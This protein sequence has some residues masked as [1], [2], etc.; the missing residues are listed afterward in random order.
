MILTGMVTIIG[1]Q[2]LMAQRGMRRGAPHFAHRGARIMVVKRSPFLPAKVVV[3]HPVWCPGMAIYRRWVFFPRYNFY[4][5]NWRNCYFFWQGGV[6]VTSPTPPP[7]V[8]NVNLVK[9]KHYELKE[10]EDDT[11]DVYK[12]ND[13]HKQEYKVD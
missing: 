7:V 5:D 9:E 1:Q 8:V 11:D 13:A 10:T 6:W 3:F 4:W 2:N 12:S